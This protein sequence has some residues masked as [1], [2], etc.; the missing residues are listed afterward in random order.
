MEKKALIVVDMLN[1]FV[2]ENGA[3]YCGAKARQI[4]PFVR[5]QIASCRKQ[6]DLIIYL[7]DSHS[8]D[9]REFEVFPRHSVDGTWGHEVIPELT[10]EPDDLVVKKR[11]YSGFFQTP[12]E[13]ILKGHQ[14]GEVAVTG[15]CTSI[16]VMDTVGGLRNR[17]YPVTVYREG[18]ADFDERF[19]EFSLE[20]MEKIYKANV[21]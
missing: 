5:A 13:E 11:R 17:D 10:P 21:M 14:I 3:L 7:Q 19:H 4:I 8:E 2:D 16:C 15:V 1:D 9:D 20:R 18:V 12:L 6:G